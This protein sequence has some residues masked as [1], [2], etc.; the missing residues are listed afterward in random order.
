MRA[1]GDDAGS[2]GA[3]FVRLGTWAA[4]TPVIGARPA[5]VDGSRD[6]PRQAL[7]DAC[8]CACTECNAPYLEFPTL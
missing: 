3:V 1:R 8:V 4:A 6:E 7:L 2:C 5:P